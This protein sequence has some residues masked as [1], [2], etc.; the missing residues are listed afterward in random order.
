VAAAILALLED[1]ARAR[2]M[3]EAGRR[4]VEEELNWAE[5]TRRLLEAAGV[6]A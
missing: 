1:P 5:F 4:R 2:R 6:N 3:G